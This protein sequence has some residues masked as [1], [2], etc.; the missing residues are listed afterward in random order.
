MRPRHLSS[1]I[2]NNTEYQLPTGPVVAICL[3][4]CAEEYITQASEAGL[5][6]NWKAIQDRNR[7]SLFDQ[8]GYGL[9][10]A[11]FPTLTQSNHAA[12]VCGATPE[13]TG[14]TGAIFLDKKTNKEVSQ[15]DPQQLR[16]KTVLA[17]LS[18][19]GV[20]ITVLTATDD[21]SGILSA[22]LQPQQDLTIAGE[23]AF[24][25]DCIERCRT[26]LGDSLKLVM[27]THGA[28]EWQSKDQE[29]LAVELGLLPVELA[30][31][32]L[33]KRGAHGPAVYFVSTS[34]ALQLA[35]PPGSEV[36]NRFYATLDRSLGRMDALGATIG[37]T[38][39][40]GMNDKTRFD[41][42]PRVVFAEAV[43]HALGIG[44]RV[45]LPIANAGV[46]DHTS[47]G[48]YATVYLEDANDEAAALTALRAQEGVYT[49][50]NN[51]EA[52]KNFALPRDRIGDIVIFGD[53]H[54]VIGRSPAFHDLSRA[55]HLRSHGG[56]EEGVVPM[57][58]NTPLQPEYNKK[59][60]RG[61]ARNYHLF[62]YLLNGMLK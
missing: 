28:E 58:F 41:G 31:A 2:V 52:A 11:A 18:A 20:P 29:G 4:G 39:D 14:I 59:L 24:S 62:D 21:I 38:A 12:L 40:H 47:L 15:T 5:M 26:P 43:L 16:C 45:V 61:K 44:C 53:K 25:T 46:N 33:S 9:V 10:T 8:N 54:S 1:V 23:D 50:M 35:E 30:N 37:L 34:A 6:P 7:P 32:I 27:E 57:W 56:L 17:A 36:A 55:P 60:K 42:S 48:S 19:K 22:G 51:E 13:V 49:A 3:A